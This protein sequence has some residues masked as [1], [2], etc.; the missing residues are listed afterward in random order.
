MFK[1]HPKGIMILFLIEMWERFGFYIMSAVYVLYMDKV[2]LFDD[3]KKGI[4]YGLFLATAYLFPLLGGWLGDK[5]FGQIK[6]IRFGVIIMITGYT[7]LAISGYQMEISFYTGLI[8]IAVGTGI[9]KVNMS[10]LVGNLYKDKEELKDAGFNIFYMGVNVGATIG[11]LAATII[12]ILFEDYNITFWAAAIGMF[13]SLIS[14]EIG[15]KQLIKA[16]TQSTHE[17]NDSK[18]NVQPME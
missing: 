11:P 18:T 14:L 8:L 15:K 1:K 4:L 6:T 7:G 10:V 16:D 2:M 12:G 5:I 3:A 17:E 13:I 9:F